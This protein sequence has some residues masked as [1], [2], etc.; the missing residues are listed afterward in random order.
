MLKQWHVLQLQHKHDCRTTVQAMQLGWP[1]NAA[2]QQQVDRPCLEVSTALSSKEGLLPS[3][4]TG[5]C[6]RHTQVTCNR[7]KFAAPT[8]DRGLLATA[9]KPRTQG[10]NIDRCRHQNPNPP[11]QPSQLIPNPPN[12]SP[13][14]LLPTS[15][16]YEHGEGGPVP[17]SRGQSRKSINL[18]RRS[19]T[20]SHTSHTH[21]GTAQHTRTIRAVGDGLAAQAA[22][23]AAAAAVAHMTQQLHIQSRTHHL[24]LQVAVG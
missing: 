14:L 15:T 13:P 5:G 9:C 1:H 21:Q 12:Q 2:Q 3:D 19:L 18:L 24:L 23:A 7:A 17:T 8:T 6:R 4:T 16:P 11:T 22:P 10:G 20:H